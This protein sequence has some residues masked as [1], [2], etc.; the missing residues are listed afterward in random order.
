MKKQNNIMSKKLHCNKPK[1]YL[2]NTGYLYT[3][4]YTSDSIIQKEPVVSK[5][6][7]ETRVYG[8]VLKNQDNQYYK[9]GKEE[10]EITTPSLLFA[11][12]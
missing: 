11:A 7:P 10:S 12:K 3:S 5:L 6:F 1:K 8:Y 4:Q 9:Y 2:I